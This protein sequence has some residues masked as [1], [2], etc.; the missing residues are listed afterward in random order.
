VF[1]LLVC[2]DIVEDDRRQDVAHVLSDLGP[3]VQLSVFECKVRGTDELNRLIG[4][5][6]SL[7]DPVQDQ[8]RVYNFGARESSPV[9]VGQRTIEEWRDYLIL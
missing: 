9:I 4:Q 8:V 6:Q 3:R 1:T 2:Y 7:I 5:L